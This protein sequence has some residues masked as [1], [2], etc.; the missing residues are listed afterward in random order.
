MS[1]NPI[2]E[3]RKAIE[4]EFQ[5]ML[6]G[7]TVADQIAEYKQFY[8]TTIQGDDYFFKMFPEKEGNSIQLA[9]CILR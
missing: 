8:D 4:K 9:L 6:Y 2:I 1:E 5:Q 7:M 3:K